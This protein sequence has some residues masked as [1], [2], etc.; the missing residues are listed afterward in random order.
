[1][2]M[3]F[4]EPG[5]ELDDCRAGRGVRLPARAVA[6]GQHG[7]ERGRRGLARRPVRRAVRAG[8]KR[9]FGILRVLADVVLVG[10][11]T[12]RGREVQARPPPPG[13]RVAARGP[14][15]RPR[16]SRSITGS[17]DLDLTT[18]AVHRRA[19]GRADDRD[20]LRGGP[21][22]SAGGRRQGRRRDRGRA[23]QR[24]TWRRRCSALADRGLRRVNCRGRPAPA[25]P[26]RRGRPAG[27]ALLHRQPHAGRAGRGPHH[28]G[29]AFA[30]DRM[31]LAHVLTE[32][33]FLF[34]RY[35]TSGARESGIRVTR[36]T[37]DLFASQAWVANCSVKTYQLR[38]SIWTQSGSVPDAHEV[39]AALRVAVGMLVP[40]AASRP[41]LTSELTLAESSALSRLERGGPATSSEL[42]RLD[43]I[44]PQ[45]M[46][47][48]V[49][50]LLRTAA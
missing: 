38:L 12:A 23:R 2:R 22:R 26:D 24:S 49:A 21:A 34:F 25:G 47:V 29:P 33:G 4:P 1:M 17:L 6:A 36:P 48:T 10:A 3:I 13:P 46:G 11:G 45:S 43:R 20:H 30:A 19:A 39:A 44:S 31:T 32:D 15:G 5:D 7:D 41:R 40:Q 27:R 42:A 28:R 9:V 14:P 8:D 50:A 37:Q 16:R 35:L 18:S